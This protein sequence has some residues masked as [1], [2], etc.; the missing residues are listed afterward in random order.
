MARIITIGVGFEKITY[1]HLRAIT[2]AEERK[3][4]AKYASI[5]DTDADA[6]ID[7]H[8]KIHAEAIAEWSVKKPSSDREGNLPI[9]QT[10]SSPKEAVE[11]FFNE[12]DDDN[13]RL[14]NELTAAYRA[15]LQ[16]NV[17][18]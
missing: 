5:P 16:P 10:V 9:N 6:Q 2:L 17:V 3:F 18:F 8:T 4:A 11:E 13:S 12:Q 7:Q 15:K 1:F 14:I